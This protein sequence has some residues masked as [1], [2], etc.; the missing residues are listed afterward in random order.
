MEFYGNKWNFQKYTQPFLTNALVTY[1]FQ[2][3]GCE[4]KI[5]YRHVGLT[6]RGYPPPP[7]PPTNVFINT[8]FPLILQ[9]TLVSFIYKVG[10]IG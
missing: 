9:A 3:I 6:G 1:I 5:K 4:P 7:S 10:C 2:Y 8:Y